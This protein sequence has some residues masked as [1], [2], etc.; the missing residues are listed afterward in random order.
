LSSIAGLST[1]GFSVFSIRLLLENVLRNEDGKLVHQEDILNLARYDA[2][3][4][5]SHQIPY[6]PSRVVLQDFTGVP[7]VLDLAAMRDVMKKLKNNFL[8]CYLKCC[9]LTP[10]TIISK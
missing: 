10:I 5:A 8:N 2:R 7:A 6:M 9:N 3:K 4:V 1:F